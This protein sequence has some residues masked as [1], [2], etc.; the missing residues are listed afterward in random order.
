MIFYVM[1]KKNYSK[2]D[3]KYFKI[4]L[5]IYTLKIPFWN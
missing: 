3:Q 2:Y 1:N 5:I 4:F